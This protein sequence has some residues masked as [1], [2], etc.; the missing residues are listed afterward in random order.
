MFQS[1]RA[2]NIFLRA[3]TN[4]AAKL[5]LRSKTTHLANKGHEINF[6]PKPERMVPL[7]IWIVGLFGFSS[8]V[9]G[10]QNQIGWDG[11][12][13]IKS[14]SA[15][16]T[17]GHRR[18]QEGL[19]EL[20]GNLEKAS[21]PF[22]SFDS[23]GKIRSSGAIGKILSKGVSSEDP[24]TR[25]LA[26]RLLESVLF[27]YNGMDSI[28]DDRPSFR[29]LIR[30]I[31][32]EVFQDH[33]DRFMLNSEMECVALKVFSEVCV[34]LCTGE[35]TSNGKDDEKIQWMRGVIVKE[36]NKQHVK[37]NGIQKLCSMLEEKVNQIRRTNIFGN[38]MH[39][40][41]DY[42][43]MRQ[44]MKELDY[45]LICIGALSNVPSCSKNKKSLP[46][47]LKILLSLSKQTMSYED[48]QSQLSSSNSV[49][50]TGPK[51]KIDPFVVLKTMKNIVKYTD[52]ENVDRD[53][54]EYL[55][56]HNNSA[57]DVLS[58]LTNH[59][60]TLLDDLTG[61]SLIGFG[62]GVLRSA[63]SMV[64]LNAAVKGGRLLAVGRVGLLTSLGTCLLTALINRS[65]E[66]HKTI[67]IES[68]TGVITLCIVERCLGLSMLFITLRSISPFS[69]FPVLLMTM[70]RTDDNENE[71]FSVKYEWN[72]STSG[73]S[74]S[75]GSK[76]RNVDNN[77]RR[78]KSHN[79]KYEE[80]EGGGSG[81]S[82][83]V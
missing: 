21:L 57:W 19:Y 15:G 60:L 2:T 71:G 61:A 56:T 38:G 74:G 11:K 82:V 36:L 25:T 83:E 27:K 40:P 24:T 75:S 31:I 68:N 50:V 14:S 80:E 72:S 55:L 52:D 33:D 42:W 16:S 54:K 62:W 47:T 51:L 20:V 41:M 77:K 78:N 12:D 39:N 65:K 67:S 70:E 69:F 79:G 59:N 73:S 8:T 26:Y 1:F 44:Q 49:V 3:N 30:A 7:A 32:Q 28:G 13:A 66:F 18:Q 45:L 48:N 9:S 22:A 37:S 58:K 81:G 17:W 29:K 10:M 43:A 76:S 6:P 34:Q 63:I 4:V 53:V 5:F 23:W 64:G 35:G 46:S